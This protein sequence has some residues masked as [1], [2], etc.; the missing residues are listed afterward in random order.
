MPVTLLFGY[1]LALSVGVPLALLFLAP[2]RERRGLL[3]ASFVIGYAL[4]WGGALLLGFLSFFA[5]GIAIATLGT[6]LALA[7]LYTWQDERFLARFDARLGKGATR[8][9][10]VDELRARIEALGTGERRDVVAGMELAGFA[11]QRLVAHGAHEDALVVLTEIDERLGDRVGAE[12]RHLRVLRARVLLQLGN[13]EDA[14]RVFE[15]ELD[16][17]TRPTPEIRILGALLAVTGVRPD[18]G[19]EAPARSF[20]AW[21]DAVVQLVRAHEAA[22]AGDDAAATRELTDLASRPYGAATLDLARTLPG[23]ATELAR[24]IARPTAPYR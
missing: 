19:A 1:A 11:V 3:A 16:P 7:A 14:V 2:V 12:R 21:N 22:R 4:A 20:L 18:P 5:V 10:A 15:A 24:R 23:P 9:E 8:E 13:P 6:L 17:R